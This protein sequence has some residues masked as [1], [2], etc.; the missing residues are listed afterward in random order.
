ML[1]IRPVK[2]LL[3]ATDLSDGA[4]YALRYAVRLAES[5]DGEVHLLH[6]LEPLSTEARITLQSL[7]DKRLLEQATKRRRETAREMM[8]QRQRDFWDEA[9]NEPD[10]LRARVA[11]IEVIEGNAA[12]VIL[13]HAARIKAD[14]ILMG[15]HEQGF[16]HTFLGRI[17]QR[18]LR[19]SRIP[20]LIIPYPDN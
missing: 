18:V 20:T 4:I 6:A 5:V 8:A 12:D 11:S 9:G 2:K 1:P 14:M 16:S 10:N 7:T 17:A 15:S 19:R 13:T 3:Y